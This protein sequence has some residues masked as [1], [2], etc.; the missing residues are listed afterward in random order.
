MKTAVK[1]KTKT[2]KSSNQRAKPTESQAKE[3]LT[4]LANEFASVEGMMS[5]RHLWTE[6][7]MHRYRINWW[8]NGGI[9]SSEFVYVHQ[10]DDG[11]IVIRKATDDK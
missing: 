5:P 11:S 6:C 9:A 3:I 8:I 1:P 4:A 7:G 10:E 2:Q